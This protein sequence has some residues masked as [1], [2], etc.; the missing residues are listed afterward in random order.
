MLTLIVHVQPAVTSKSPGDIYALKKMKNLIIKG[1]MDL[2]CL[3]FF[4]S[5]TLV[6]N[7]ALLGIVTINIK[8]CE[9]YWAL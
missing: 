8:G 5:L 9:Y 7:T 6:T 1:C 3:D 4:L 2:G